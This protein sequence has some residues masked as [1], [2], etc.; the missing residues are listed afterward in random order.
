MRCHICN[1]VLSSPNPN[2][3]HG[4]YDP[5][6]TCMIVINDTVAG[7]LDKP[8]ADEDDLGGPEP[9]SVPPRP[10]SPDNDE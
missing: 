8:S 1:S 10:Y 9:V 7:F 2:S 3:D 4:D 5:C 6:E